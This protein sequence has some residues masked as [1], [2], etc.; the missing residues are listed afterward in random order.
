MRVCER[1]RNIEHELISAAINDGELTALIVIATISQRLLPLRWQ[2][3]RALILVS[4]LFLYLGSLEAGVI[5]AGPIQAPIFLLV[6]CAIGWYVLKG[7]WPFKSK[8]TDKATHSD[9]RASDRASN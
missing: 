4:I 5:S 9:G 6:Y 1:D 7:T 2:F 3:K 8:V